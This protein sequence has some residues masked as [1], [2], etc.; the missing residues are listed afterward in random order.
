[1]AGRV[2]Y[3][4]VLEN[5]A[6][7]AAEEV[8]WPAGSIALG[9]NTYC[10]LQELDSFSMTVV[11]TGAAAITQCELMHSPDGDS[12]N[13]HNEVVH[14]FNAGG[15]AAQ[16]TTD[17]YQATDTRSNDD[18]GGWRLTATCGTATTI[19]IYVK[20]ILKE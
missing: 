10:D 19:S 2:V 12:T 8:G 9:D 20:G 7:A 16:H 1:M 11:V 14:D 4:P 15:V 18:N 5:I 6:I 17:T 3:F 13:D